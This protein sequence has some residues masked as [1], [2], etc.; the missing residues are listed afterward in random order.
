M[1]ILNAMP[2]V[3]MLPHMAYYTDQASDDMV[4]MSLENAQLLYSGAPCPFEIL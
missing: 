2:N 4:R 3:L 1:A